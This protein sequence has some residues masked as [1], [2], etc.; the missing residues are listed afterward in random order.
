MMEVPVEWNPT[1]RPGKPVELFQGD[2]EFPQAGRHYDVS[3]DGTRFL[4]LKHAVQGDDDYAVTPQINVVL[5]W[6][7]GLLERVPIP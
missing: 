6:H 5:N 7:Q 2:Y 1:F 4:M 3:P